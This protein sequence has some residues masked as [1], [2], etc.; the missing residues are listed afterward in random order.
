MAVA[1]GVL[2]VDQ[3]LLSLHRVLTLSSSVYTYQIVVCLHTIRTVI[4]SL[5]LARLYAAL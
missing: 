2:V 5:L 1:Q 4:A 3:A